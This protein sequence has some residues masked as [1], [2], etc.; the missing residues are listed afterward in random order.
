MLFK[1]NYGW[2]PTFYRSW[3]RS[4]EQELVKKKPESVKNG[5][6]PQHWLQ[7]HILW[8]SWSSVDLIAI[9]LHYKLYTTHFLLANYC[10]QTLH[11]PWERHQR[12][13]ISPQGPEPA[14]LSLQG[15]SYSTFTGTGTVPTSDKLTRPCTGNWSD[16][17]LGYADLDNLFIFI[18]IHGCC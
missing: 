6:A 3:S 16:G 18:K 8:V 13:E 15:R 4:R 10:F 2:K 12:A 5:L 11:W 17:M 7:Q 1:K 9:T 14:P